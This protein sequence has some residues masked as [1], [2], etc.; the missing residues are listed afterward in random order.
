M[1]FRSAHSSIAGRNTPPR[2]AGLMPM[3]SVFLLLLAF[4]IM[5]VSLVEFD[6]R[7]TQAALQ[8]L[9]ATF[10]AHS[11]DSSEGGLGTEQAAAGVTSQLAVELGAVLQTHLREGRYSIAVNE[12]TAFVEIDNS[13]LFESDLTPKQ[14]L[15]RISVD[16]VAMLNNA[17]RRFRYEIDILQ[18]LGVA[19]A[20][21]RAGMLV[22]SFEAAGMSSERLLIGLT[23]VNAAR[24]RIEIHTVSPIEHAGRT[25]WLSRLAV[26]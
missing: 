5:L 20:T 21:R 18:P 8:S 9:N 26:Q 1:A 11:F 25:R 19:G 7:R 17:P 22:R 16:T 10:K 14:K 6:E 13:E 2:Q 23:T 4:F 3:L 24:T 12:T 15:G